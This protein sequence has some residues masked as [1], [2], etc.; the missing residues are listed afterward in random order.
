MLHSVFGDDHETAIL[1]DRRAESSRDG[2]DE[3][4]AHRERRHHHEAEILK[5]RGF[6]SIRARPAHR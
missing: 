1:Y 4:R 2:A 5:M 6:Y 3:M